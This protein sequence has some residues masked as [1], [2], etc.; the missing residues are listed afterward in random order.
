MRRLLFGLICACALRLTAPAHV[1]DQY[2]QVAQIAI[3]TGAVRVTLRLTPGTQV[4]DRVFALID[5]DR[6]GRIS[7]AEEQSYTRR[8]LQDVALDV[9]GRRTPL[10][11]TRVQFPS[12]SEINEGVGAIRFDLEAEADLNKAGEHQVSFRNDHLPELGTYLANALVPTSQAIRINRQER[13]ELQHGL[14]IYFHATPDAAREWPL[15]AGILLFFLCVAILLSQMKR[16]RHFYAAG[17]TE[18]GRKFVG[19]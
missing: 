14:R 16:I 5:L 4:A 2:L 3:E 11:V 19:R 17:R 12:R 8:V 10:S 18:P 13:D 9:D 6:D 15:W 7:P 1:L